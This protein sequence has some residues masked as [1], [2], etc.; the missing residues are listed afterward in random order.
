M[1]PL[2]VART[3]DHF[4]SS[5]IILRIH[6]L[7]GVIV[8]VAVVSW[9]TFRLY[10]WTLKKKFTLFHLRYSNLIVDTN[11]IVVPSFYILENKESRIK[12]RIEFFKD[13][14]VNKPPLYV[15]NLDDFIHTLSTSEH[16]RILKK[17]EDVKTNWN[18]I[19]GIKLFPLKFE[20]TPTLKFISVSKNRSSAYID[21]A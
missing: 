11:F 17:V 15:R 4:T 6:L 13:E 12:S 1:D 10:W 9:L 5:P 19:R 20:H 8:G 2:E 14:F 21:L 3:S 16:N 7:T 18:Y